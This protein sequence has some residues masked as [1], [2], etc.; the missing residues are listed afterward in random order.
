VDFW[1]ATIIRNPPLI[2]LSSIKGLW[3]EK[4]QTIKEAALL[5]V[6]FHRKYML[7]VLASVYISSRERIFGTNTINFL[8]LITTFSSVC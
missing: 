4:R 2:I 6:S 3:A 5:F 7:S 1:L 8:T